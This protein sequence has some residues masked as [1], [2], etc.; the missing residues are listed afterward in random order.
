MR[1]NP[2]GTI[3]EAAEEATTT[4]E[5][6][7]EVDLEALF[8]D[9]ETLRALLQ[10]LFSGPAL[11]DDADVSALPT[12]PNSFEDENGVAYGHWEPLLKGD[13]YDQADIDAVEKN[14]IVVLDSADDPEVALSDFH[15]I[16]YAHPGANH[17]FAACL[18]EFGEK[19]YTVN[20]HQDFRYVVDKTAAV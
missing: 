12:L 16:A 3:P 13:E 11:P 14:E 15:F 5:F 18:K 1:S 6:P 17:P 9:D 19:K 20:G 2:N 10:N 4:E 8:G 7:S